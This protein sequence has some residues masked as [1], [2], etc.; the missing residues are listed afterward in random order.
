MDKAKEELMLA[1]ACIEEAYSLYE[2]PLILEALEGV[3][4]ALEESD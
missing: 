1:I 4:E 3:Q 2:S